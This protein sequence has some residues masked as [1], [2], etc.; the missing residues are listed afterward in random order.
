MQIRGHTNG[1]TSCR[2]I[3]QPLRINPHR[4]HAPTSNGA[5]RRVKAQRQVYKESVA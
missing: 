2:N 1:H 4:Q 3:L 5:D